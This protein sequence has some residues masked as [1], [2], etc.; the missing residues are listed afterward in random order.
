MSVANN[1]GVNTWNVEYIEMT[2]IIQ[3]SELIAYYNRR[4]Y[5]DT[6]LRKPFPIHDIRLGTPKRKDLEFCIMQKCV[7]KT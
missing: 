2:I 7:K 6:G 3:R 4:G 1:Y 5:V